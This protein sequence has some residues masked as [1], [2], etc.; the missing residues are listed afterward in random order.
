MNKKKATITLS[1]G[2]IAVIVISMM[3]NAGGASYHHKEYA[4][5]ELEAYETLALGCVDLSQSTLHD[6]NHR[7][8][9]RFRPSHSYLSNTNI[10]EHL[11]QAAYIS[12]EEEAAVIIA[13]KIAENEAEIVAYLIEWEELGLQTVEWSSFVYDT[14]DGVTIM[15]IFFDKYMEALQIA[16]EI[17]PN[18]P[19]VPWFFRIFSY[20]SHVEPGL[21]HIVF[22]QGVN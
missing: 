6:P 17:Y 16:G 15:H 2:I 7:S 4:E 3:I 14:E 12:L 13:M 10:Q 22:A 1:V 5:I 18:S 20:P 21:Y 9:V 11:A 19:R 8:Q